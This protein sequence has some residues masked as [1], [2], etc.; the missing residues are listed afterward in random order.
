MTDQ[1]WI[2]LTGGFT[3]DGSREHS[4]FRNDAGDRVLIFNSRAAA[5]NHVLTSGL[6]K[7]SLIAEVIATAYP[8]TE[9]R[10]DTGSRIVTTSIPLKQDG[11]STMDDMMIV[12]RALLQRA[13]DALEE[14][15]DCFDAGSDTW[16]LY[17]Q[18]DTFLRPDERFVTPLVPMK[19]D[20]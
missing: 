7:F 17:H 15:P 3:G 2:V 6:G 13:Y 14:I 8:A 9:L 16:V 11:G 10:F 12:P 4:L 18:I 20:R 1:K 5:E 19:P